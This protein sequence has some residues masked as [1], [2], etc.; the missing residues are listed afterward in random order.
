[1]IPVRLSPSASWHDE[2]VP[3]PD[4]R[5][6]LAAERTHLAYVRTSLALFGGSIVA[7]GYLDHS[8]HG[9]LAYAAA[10]GLFVAGLVVIVGGYLRVRAV[11]AAINSGEP[12]PSTWLTGLVSALV[13]GTAIVGVLAIRFS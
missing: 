9:V 7:L 11:T 2:T 5:F 10:L 6:S 4:A 8:P 1:L 3:E 12:L 13:L